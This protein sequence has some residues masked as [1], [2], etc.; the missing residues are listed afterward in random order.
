MQQCVLR[1]DRRIIEP[2]RNRM[3]RYNLPTFVLK[4]VRER[5]V[6]HAGPPAREPGRMITECWSTASRLDTDHSNLF[7]ADEVVEQA[8]RIAAAAHA[9]HQ[10][11]RQSAF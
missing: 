8:D 2:R 3:C 9:S 11:I 5:P 10:D 7:L 1:S 4:D 6:K